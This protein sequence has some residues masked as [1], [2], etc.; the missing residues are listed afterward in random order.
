MPSVEVF[1]LPKYVLAQIY[2]GVTTKRISDIKSHD[3]L[4]GDVG[5]QKNVAQPYIQLLAVR[6]DLVLCQDEQDQKS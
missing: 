4:F 1:L 3:H 5:E 2:R 6:D